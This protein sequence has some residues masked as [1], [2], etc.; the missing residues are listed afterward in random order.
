MGNKKILIGV[1]FLLI[2]FGA[3][4]YYIFYN[5]NSEPNPY[6]FEVHSHGYEVRN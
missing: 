1:G 5:K 2:I 6:D 3:V 4:I